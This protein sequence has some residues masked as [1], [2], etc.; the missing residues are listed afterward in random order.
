M[1]E[2]VLVRSNTKTVN[3]FLLNMSKY[4]IFKDL[5]NGGASVNGGW[6]GM[7]WVPGFR[8][9]KGRL[10]LVV[11]N[12]PKTKY[13]A[14]YQKMSNVKQLLGKDGAYLMVE[15]GVT[16]EMEAVVGMGVKE[17]PSETLT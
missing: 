7:Q 17:A 11:Q 1:D 14:W 10:D 12:N 4:G 6:L 3:P 13:M 5:I 8:N 15:K 2:M 9:N 16:V